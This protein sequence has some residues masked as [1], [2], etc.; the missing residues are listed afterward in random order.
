VA[1][2]AK[3]LIRPSIDPYGLCPCGGEKRA[4]ACCLGADGN[5][6]K[7]VSS[8]RPP[9]PITGESQNGC[10]LGHIHDCAGGISREHYVSRDALEELS[11]GVV[12]IDGFFWQPPGEQKIV[13]I[14]SLTGNILCVRHNS[15]LSPLDAEAGQ[16][17]RTIKHIHASLGRRS[18]SRKTTIS[19]V[20][21]EALEQWILKVACG[22]FYAKIASRDRH[23]I[24]KDHLVEDSIIAEGLF[25]KRWHRDCGL[26]MRAA[27]GQLVPGVNTISLVPATAT[28]GDEKRY[29][30]VRVS[31]IGLE[32]AVLFD[33]RGL[34]PDQL[35]AEG[36]Y[37]RPS[38]V[39]F[40]SQQRRHWLI[41][42]WPPG[43]PGRVIEMVMTP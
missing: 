32:F 21:G 7:H 35:A 36:W 40:R 26:Y 33:P 25:S 39:S 24:A 4:A 29:V 27:V 23:Q 12:A 11:E 19:I 3:R 34:Y 30:G 37:L 22:L 20:S 17:M 31:M 42:T 38:D 8:L 14:N 15:A 6:R 9:P 28:L 1:N 41:L 13:G 2:P 43:T 5:V 10:Y 18:L 16:F